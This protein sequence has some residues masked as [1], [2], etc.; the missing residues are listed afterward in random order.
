MGQTDRELLDYIKQPLAKH[1][2]KMKDVKIAGYKIYYGDGSVY[3]ARGPYSHLFKEWKKAPYENIQIIMLYEN[4]YFGADKK[5]YR[6]SMSG[7]DY[8]LFD[9]REFMAC[10]D[11]RKF[12]AIPKKSLKYGW[13]VDRKNLNEINKKAMR[14]FWLEGDS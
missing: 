6:M 7:F 2:S 13:Y 12:P 1:R 9:G 5:H 4:K 3:A 11:T 8:Y 14:D 10:N